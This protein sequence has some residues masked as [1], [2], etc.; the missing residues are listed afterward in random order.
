MKQEDQKIGIKLYPTYSQSKGLKKLFDNRKKN[1][2]RIPAHLFAEG[3]L[4]VGDHK[5]GRVYDPIQFRSSIRG[6]ENGSSWESLGL[7]TLIKD[8][9]CLNFEEFT[10]E[11]TYHEMVYIDNPLHDGTF[12]NEDAYY[13]DENN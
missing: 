6:K 1:G 11:G 4:N 5:S 8:L 13:E 7:P 12:R 10:F 2:G 3:K 9:K